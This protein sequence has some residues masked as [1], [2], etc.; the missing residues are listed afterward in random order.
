MLAFRVL[1]ATLMV[2]ALYGFLYEE[3]N[4]LGN[5]HIHSNAP[6]AVGNL[7]FR[8]N[9]TQLHS[10]P[11]A[12]TIKILSSPN[13]TFD[14]KTYGAHHKDLLDALT[15]SIRQRFLPLLDHFQANL[16]QNSIFQQSTTPNFD[17]N[18]PIL[19]GQN[20]SLPL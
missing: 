6:D 20:D 8:R 17:N 11:S 15:S 18:F 5:V 10:C 13:V 16:P 19:L 7:E 1:A 4:I 14:L 9:E 3:M 12:N 2:P